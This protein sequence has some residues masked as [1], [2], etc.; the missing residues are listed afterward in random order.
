MREVK[1]QL[2]DLIDM[3]VNSLTAEQSLELVKELDAGQGSWDFTHEVF[4]YVLSIINEDVKSYKEFLEDMEDTKRDEFQNLL[5]ELN[6]KFKIFTEEDIAGIN[7]IKPIVRVKH[8]ELERS[9]DVSDYR[10]K[11]P[12]CKEGTL[13]M[14]RNPVT[15]VLDKEDMCALCGQRFEYTDIDEIRGP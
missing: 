13:L 2:Y 7:I 5:D 15:F 9:D 12:E 6:P 14:R 3:M 4:K 10:S 8:S 1:V 11:C